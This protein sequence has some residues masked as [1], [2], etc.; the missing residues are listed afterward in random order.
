MIAAT[1]ID[2]NQVPSTLAFEVKE[3]ADFQTLRKF[4]FI[5]SKN[6]ENS[7]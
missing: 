5:H 1:A 3:K 6:K 4:V 2:F 7:V